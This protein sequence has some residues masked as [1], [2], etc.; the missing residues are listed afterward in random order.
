MRNMNKVGGEKLLSIWWFFVLVIVGAGIVAGVFLNYSKE[1][2]VR[3]PEAQILGERIFGCI[4][5]NGDLK[6]NVLD[7]NFDIFSECKINKSLFGVGSRFYFNLKINH[8]EGKE[9]REPILGGL[10]PL[11]KDCLVTS[12]KEEEVIGAG[13]FPGCYR[14]EIYVGYYIG[15]KRKIAKVVLLTASNNRGESISITKT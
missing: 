10:G 2:D 11:E 7:K 12:G 4:I 6:E 13:N 5:Q 15:G 8:L 14:K 1:A 9:L 3:Q